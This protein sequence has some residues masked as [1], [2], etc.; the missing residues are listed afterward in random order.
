[1]YGKAGAT[2]KDDRGSAKGV[3]LSCTVRSEPAGSARY[4]LGGH[5]DA[6]NREAA[7]PMERSE[8]DGSGTMLPH[9]SAMIRNIVSNGGRASSKPALASKMELFIH[10]LFTG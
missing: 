3:E 1:M 9:V 4:L 8:S 10:L 6:V 5:P 7:L 2:S